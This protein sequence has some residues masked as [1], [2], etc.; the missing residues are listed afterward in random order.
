MVVKIVNVLGTKYE[1]S[2]GTREELNMDK[3]TYGECEVYSKQIR[4]CTDPEPGVSEETK[5]T[6]ISEV[7]RHELSHAFLYESGLIAFS[8]D[9]TL[10]EWM[11]VNM[12]KVLSSSEI[13]ESEFKSEI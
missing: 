8:T 1:A 9:E 7:I 5:N 11:S 10:V 12:S 3:D 4:V 2:F 13:L 6:I